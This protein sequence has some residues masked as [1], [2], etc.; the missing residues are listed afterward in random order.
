[1]L[2]KEQFF[3][4][5]IYAKDLQ[6]DNQVLTN[7]IIEWSKSDKGI[8]K[9]NVN[10]WHSTTDM[11]KKPEYKLLIDEL[12]KMQHE[13]YK[14]ELLDNEPFL[15]NMWAN[16]NY[17][18]GYNS[19]HIHANSMFSGV[20]YVKSEPNSGRLICDDPRPG[21]QHN[22]PMRKEGELPK[23]LWR[24]CEVEPIPGRLVMFPAWL[25]HRV[26]P[27]LSKDIRISISFNFLQKGLMA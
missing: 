22:I 6:L 23:H 14:E 9:T 2:I 11:H 13:I 18:G 3:P 10:G 1:M 8:N 7:H 12:Y 26:S 24:V 20:Y 5:T 25:W 19:P 16:V 15:G 27:N 17:Q 4:T 21:I